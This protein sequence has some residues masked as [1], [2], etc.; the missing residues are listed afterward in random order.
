MIT[1]RLNKMKFFAHH[2]WHDEESITGTEFEVSVFVS[3]NPKKN[4]EELNDTINYVSVF[5]IVKKRFCNPAKLLET[6]AEQITEDIHKT[7]DR[8]SVI[9]IIIDKVNPPIATFTG[10]AGITYSKSFPDEIL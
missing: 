8:I 5:N 10:T 3:F 1:V 9:N 4:I 6:L 2:G 7:D